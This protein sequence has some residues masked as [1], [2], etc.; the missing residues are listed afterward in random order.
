MDVDVLKQEIADHQTC[1]DELVTCK[2]E[3]AIANQK[4]EL[5][6]KKKNVNLCDIS[7]SL[8]KHILI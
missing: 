6:S 3:L 4:L 8:G 2:N 5:V 1:L 7:L